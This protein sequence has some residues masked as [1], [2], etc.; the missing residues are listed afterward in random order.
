MYICRIA[1]KEQRAEL[2][3]RPGMP[4]CRSSYPT[5]LMI[6]DHRV[7]GADK[8]QT[9]GLWALRRLSTICGSCF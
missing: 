1:W 6:L 2:N 4:R 3:R 5:E 9:P 7:R 8:F